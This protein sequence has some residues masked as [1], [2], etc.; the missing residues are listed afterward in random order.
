MP[1]RKA[2]RPEATSD[3]EQPPRHSGPVRLLAHDWPFLYS[4]LSNGDLV[5]NRRLPKPK[6]PAR[7]RREE[8]ADEAPF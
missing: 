5:M 6:A 1:R 8:S 2:K 3:A 7:R 4:V